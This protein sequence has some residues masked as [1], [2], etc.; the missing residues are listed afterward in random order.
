MT[1]CGLRAVLGAFAVSVLFNVVNVVINWLCGRALGLDLGLGYYFAVAPL[2][3]VSLL[4]PSLGGWGVREMVT[5]AVFA[6]AGTEK[7]AAI[8]V[9]LGLIGLG[10]GVIGGVLY[11]IEGIRGLRRRGT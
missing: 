4:V 9:L 5:H 8:G 2:I 6:S 10:A 7:G 11:A 1:G 3:S